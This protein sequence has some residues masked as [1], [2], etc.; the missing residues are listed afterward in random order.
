MDVAIA[1]DCL[2]T[3][4]CYILVFHN[5]LSVPSME[6]NLI[7]PFIMREAGIQGN[8]APKIH[9]DNPTVNDHSLFFPGAET[10][11]A[12]LLWGICS[13]FPCRIPIR[14]ELEENRVLLMTPDGSSWNPHSDVYARNEENMLD[15]EGRIV[16][17]KDRV[18]ILLSE[19][20]E[21]TA[22]V[23]SATVSTIEMQAIDTITTE[24]DFLGETIEL[25]AWN[26]VP[27]DLNEVS[28][29]MASVSLLLDP[30]V[31]LA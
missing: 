7:L 6:H 28:S 9:V 31:E 24:A 4:E 3:N 25:A 12:L 1:Y 2:F 23:S 16:E 21:D 18:R 13:Y 27:A 22:I 5:A 30:A 15:W 8:E 26:T 29:V 10:R 14:T 20:Q 19:I 17:P 11:I